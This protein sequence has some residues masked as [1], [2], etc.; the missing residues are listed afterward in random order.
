MKEETASVSGKCISGREGQKREE[1][2]AVRGKDSSE[3]KGQQ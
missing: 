1:R 3:R 2:A